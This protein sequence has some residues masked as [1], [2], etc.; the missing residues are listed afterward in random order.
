MIGAIETSDGRHAVLQNSGEWD[1]G[2]RPLKVL[3]NTIHSPHKQIDICSRALPWWGRDQVVAAAKFYGTSPVFP[4]NDDASGLEEVRG[5]GAASEKAWNPDQPRDDHG[6]WAADDGGT[7]MSGGTATAEKPAADKPAAAPPKNVEEI[8][9]RAEKIEFTEGE[10]G[11]SIDSSD[12]S[13]IYDRM[14]SEERDTMREALDQERDKW[15]NEQM[16]SWEPDDSIYDAIDESYAAS[17]AGYSQRDIK[18]DVGEM[19]ADNE[20]L[21]QVVEDWDGRYGYDGI[22]MLIEELD[23]SGEEIS[24]ELRDKLEAYK[25]EAEDAIQKERDHQYESLSDESRDSAR[26]EYENQY[27]ESDAERS[28]LERFYEDNPER[29]QSEEQLGK[30]VISPRGESQFSFKTSDERRFDVNVY[31]RELGAGIKTS[32]V[33]FSDDTGDF[34]V[35][36][37]G[38]AFEVFGQ[39]VPAVVAYIKHEDPPVVT[40]S[41]YGK[42]RQRLYD[43]LV[44]TVLGAGDG[45][46]AV[47]HDSA[48]G[49]S[50]QY[51][52]GKLDM[53]QDIISKMPPSIVENLQEIAPRKDYGDDQWEEFSVPIDPAWFTPEGWEDLPEEE[54]D[55]A[56]NP[57]QPRDEGGRWTSGPGSNS[58][59]HAAPEKEP[60][61]VSDEDLSS[62]KLFK[63]HELALPSKS[64]QVKSTKED[65]YQQAREE[66]PSFDVGL[67]TGQGVDKAI[68]ANVAR[69]TNAEE[70]KK[71][72]DSEGP[73][74]IIAGLKGEKRAEEKVN[75]KYGGDWSRLT[76]VIRATVAVSSKSEIPGAV[77]A[78]RKEM[79]D[80]GWKIAE[81]PDNRITNPTPGGY[82]DLNL[83]FRSENG[84][85]AEIQ[86]NTKAMIRAK[87]GDGH[88]LYEDYR[89]IDE[90]IKSSNREPT[91]E[92]KDKLRTLSARM[93]SLYNDAWAK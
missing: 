60:R 15:V 36:G 5:S 83:L 14:T 28:Y 92:E 2:D 41:A 33:Q 55:K 73:T 68:G 40:F 16:D 70:F 21:T 82:R 23:N 45:R 4:S 20:K 22:E 93:S 10:T 3:L 81:K 12:T 79:A 75:G 67:N 59:D 51:A 89:R 78:V 8:V 44:A 85:L 76:D 38:K 87:E 29:F 31:D 65:L 74:V 90:S 18:N 57:D 25:N 17:E 71:A 63:S 61:K 88:K 58:T 32:D 34:G 72:I 49:K 1:S 66:K 11:G 53:R 56:F 77:D 64:N 47:K 42:S 54:T 50:R 43:R 86:I 37:K 69:P 13:E 52:V 84:H 39:V 48:D 6:R 24:S 80:H 19:V 26:E 46:F 91:A 35:T 30:W 9:K 7:S 62:D 27:S